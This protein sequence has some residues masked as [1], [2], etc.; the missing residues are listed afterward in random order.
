MA[1]FPARPVR[2]AQSMQIGRAVRFY[3]QSE[4]RAPWAQ[5]GALRTIHMYAELA[6]ASLIRF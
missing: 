4:L 1:M 5:G 2:S 6:K 3:R